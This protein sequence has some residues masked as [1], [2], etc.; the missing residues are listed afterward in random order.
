MDSYRSQM[1]I[2]EDGRQGCGIYPEWTGTY[3]PSIV[4]YDS[5]YTAVQLSAL[6]TLA[7]MGEKEYALPMAISLFDTIEGVIDPSTGMLMNLNSTRRSD[8]EG[9]LRWQDALLYRIG[10]ENNVPGMVRFGYLL[11]QVSPAKNFPAD[12]HSAL[13]RY[14]D[15]KYYMAPSADNGYRLP[16]ESPIYSISFVDMDGNPAGSAPASVMSGGLIVH[17]A[18]SRQQNTF[19][20]IYPF[21]G[22]IEAPAGTKAWFNDGAV[23]LEGTG[24]ITIRYSGVDLIRLSLPGSGELTVR[25]IN[26]GGQ[27]IKQAGTTYAGG[28]LTYSTDISGKTTLKLISRVTPTQTI[29]PVPSTMISPSPSAPAD[30]KL[31]SVCVIPFIVMASCLY[32][33]VILIKKR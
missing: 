29:T 27:T 18:V 24:H 6:L 12:F 9:D 13:P 4:M 30:G 25:E 19:P 23:T 7:A 11:N 17:P 26:G 16:Q 15:L 1:S 10:T 8:K 31:R 33:F 2:I 22:T 28:T 5:S 21:Y 14:Y 3:N 32:L 20:L